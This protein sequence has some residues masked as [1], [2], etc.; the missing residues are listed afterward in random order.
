MVFSSD[1]LRP[2]ILLC[3]QISPV[4]EP[5]TLNVITNCNNLNSD[6]ESTSYKILDVWQLDS[7]QR[8]PRRH[9]PESDILAQQAVT[10]GILT[11]RSPGNNEQ[12]NLGKKRRGTS[13]WSHSCYCSTVASIY[14]FNQNWVGDPGL[15]RYY[16][17]RI[18]RRKWY[19]RPQS[20]SHVLYITPSIFF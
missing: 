1:S 13:R 15:D 2:S 11:A 14:R 17:P 20:I 3:A 10:L 5:G 18:G 8:E 12:G 4:I 7:S 9:S 19:H 6:N 16:I